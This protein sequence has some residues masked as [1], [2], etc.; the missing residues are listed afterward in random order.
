MAEALAGVVDLP[1]GGA[2]VREDNPFVAV[3]DFIGEGG[4]ERQNQS[5]CD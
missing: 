1:P 5:E 3:D 4:C 2:V